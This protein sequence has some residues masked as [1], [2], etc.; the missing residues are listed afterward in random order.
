[1]ECVEV[2]VKFV[3]HLSRIVHKIAVTLFPSGA[4]PVIV[5]LRCTFVALY[6]RFFFTSTKR[7]KGK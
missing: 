7:P 4:V 6:H 5:Q 1:M 2:Y 3:G